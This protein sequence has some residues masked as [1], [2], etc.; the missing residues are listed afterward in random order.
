MQKHNRRALCPSRDEVA[1]LTEVKYPNPPELPK[2]VVDAIRY[3]RD[4][5]WRTSG[6]IN[7]DAYDSYWNRLGMSIDLCCFGDELHYVLENYGY[8]APERPD[9][10]CVYVE[11]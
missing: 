1:D 5:L 4:Y 3:A 8:A 9:D 11:N 10:Y 7:D 6:R 2:D